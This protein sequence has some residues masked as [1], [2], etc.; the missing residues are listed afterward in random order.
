VSGD[1]LSEEGDVVGAKAW[2]GGAY[3]ASKLHSRTKKILHKSVEHS[4]SHM[5]GHNIVHFI[6]VVILAFKTTV[7][8]GLSALFSWAFRP[9][10]ALIFSVGGASG[11][12][13]W[14]IL[15]VSRH[16]VDMFRKI[17]F[18]RQRFLTWAF[19]SLDTDGS[20][21]IDETEA[22]MAFRLVGIPFTHKQ[23]HAR[24]RAFDRDRNG[25]IDFD[26]FCHEVTRVWHEQDEAKRKRMAAE[27][28]ARKEA[29][30]AAQAAQRGVA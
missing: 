30:K 4:I 27:R 12:S 26:E 6:N 11:V 1:E 23:M 20:G 8:G 7:I 18:L 29:K 9:I 25:K 13:T 2:P 28:R 22:L 17:P 14:T 10:G 5:I 24:F 21:F 15:E 19:T 16:P 3:V